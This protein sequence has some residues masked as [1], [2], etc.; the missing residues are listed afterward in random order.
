MLAPSVSQFEPG[1]N[2]FGF[3]LF[4]RSRAQIADVPAAVYVAP[5]GGGQARG[6]IVARY[7]SLAVK[8]QFQSRSVASDPT[9]RSR[10]TWPT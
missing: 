3:G 4:D 10:S 7:E 6:P 1:S 9:P 5:V 2:R 8:A